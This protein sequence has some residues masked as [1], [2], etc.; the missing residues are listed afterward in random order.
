MISA[1]AVNEFMW[2]SALSVKLVVSLKFRRYCY[3][4]GISVF[5]D[6]PMVSGF[7]SH[8]CAEVAILIACCTCPLE[9][10]LQRICYRNRSV[11]CSTELCWICYRHHFPTNSDN[12]EHLHL[13]TFSN[14]T[15]NDLRNTKYIYGISLYLK[16]QIFPLI[17]EVEQRLTLRDQVC[18]I[19][20]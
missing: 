10:G 11:D 3:V 15:A 13:L 8:I 16:R 7:V 19:H 5:L 1:T 12:P 18:G 9:T 2:C 6:V 17:S 4:P 20:S 14:I